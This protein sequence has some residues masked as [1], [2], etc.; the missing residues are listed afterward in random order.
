MKK[1]ILIALFTILLLPSGM[2]QLVPLISGESNELSLDLNRLYNYNLYEKSRYG[3]GLQYDIALGG[4]RFNTLSLSGYGAYGY[5]DERFK[6]GLKADLQGNGKHQS[7]TYVEFFHDLTADASRYLNTYQLLN[8]TSTGSFMTRLFSD[9]YRLTLGFSRQV[10]AKR[11]DGF[12]LRFSRERPLHAGTAQIYP[13]SYSDLKDLPY[14]DFIEG[15]F[16]V[17]YTSGLRGELLTGFIGS[18][19]NGKLSDPDASTSYRFI[20]FLRLLLQYDKNFYFSAF[21]LDLFAQCGFAQCGFANSGAPYS[22][23]FDLG[24]TWGSPLA[25]QRAL[26]TARPNEFVTNL[27]SLITLKLTTQEPL[28]RLYSNLFAIGTAPSPFLLCDA[29]WGKMGDYEGAYVPDKGIAEVGAGVD[30][31][32]VWGAVKWGGAVVYRLTPESAAYHFS[33]PKDNLTFLFTAQLNL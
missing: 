8:F 11:A 9:T 21:E 28:F 10:T 29:A 4:E 27:F 33:D 14:K 16:F 12:E 26:L 13:P 2:A 7:H 3:L 23:L 22:R 24:G 1:I 31:L 25:L 18:E 30:G 15:R 19:N 32:L 20:P 17:A 6:W 5:A